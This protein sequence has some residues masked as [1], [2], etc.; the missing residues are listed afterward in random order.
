VSNGCGQVESEIATLTL[1]VRPSIMVQP[2]SQTVC[3]RSWVM[4]SVEASGT[5]PLA[6]QWTK[7]GAEIYG[8]NEATYNILCTATRDSGSYSV[9]VSNN[10]D[11]IESE[12]AVLAVC[13][14]P[15]IKNRSMIG[16]SPETVP[17]I[18]ETPPS[19]T[20]QLK[21]AYNSQCKM[22]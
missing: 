10:C 8:A 20:V 11:Q 2:V 3:E 18:T 21:K 16:E 15:A 14:Q 13:S 4:F 12:V 17:T 22:R 7:D 19:I 6:Y 9:R 5:E 1:N